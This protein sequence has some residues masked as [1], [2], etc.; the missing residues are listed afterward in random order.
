MTVAFVTGAAGQDGTLLVRRLVA[1]GVRVHGLLLPS[2]DFSVVGARLP[3]GVVLHVGDL[4]DGAVVRD[5]IGT[6]EPD[7][8]YNLGGVSSVA[9]SWRHPART[10]AVSGTGAVNVFEASLA[11]Q[12]A[13]GRAVRVV[14]ASSA[15]MFG[16][17]DRT[18]QDESTA[19][20]PIS[21]YG[22]AKAYAHQM[23]AIF[24][25]RGL[26]VAT[27]ILYNHESPLRPE[28][29]VTRK[30]TAAAA[31]IAR[32]GGGSLA[33]GD[34]TVRRDWG[35]ADD[36]VDAMV[37][38]VRHREADDFVVA[39]GVTHSV[40][41]FV[42]AAMSVAGIEDWRRHV[43]VDPAFVRPDDAGVQVGD[44]GR[45]RRVLGWSPTV[46]FDEVVRRMVRHD[47]ELLD[48]G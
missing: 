2:D 11:A 45:A 40:E 31:R 9:Y 39:T 30:I 24:R 32:N 1:E 7:E 27:C 18:P 42:V 8:V 41:D 43:T 29:F 14:Q 22:A 15:E 38:A 28:R 25:T 36:Y 6:V 12:E 17:P 35:W 33:L 16:H 4:T 34:L 3:E 26:H 5:I 21:P 19:I 23:A 46:G 48:R 44:A 20:R 47:L 37:R 10:G 13:I